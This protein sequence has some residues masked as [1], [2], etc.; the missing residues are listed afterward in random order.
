VKNAYFSSIMLYGKCSAR[1][2]WFAK[3]FVILEFLIKLLR[4]RF[5]GA[6]RK[7]TVHKNKPK[8]K[9]FSLA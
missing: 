9:E 7:H 8:T 3:S 2:L 6:F 5:M 1:K 4:K